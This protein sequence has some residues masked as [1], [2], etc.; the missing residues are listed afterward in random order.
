MQARNTVHRFSRE[1][2]ITLTLTSAESHNH[3][4]LQGKRSILESVWVVGE[5]PWASSWKS[6]KMSCVALKR[7]HDSGFN[8]YFCQSL[9]LDKLHCPM[10]KFYLGVTSVVSKIVSSLCG[11]LYCRGFQTASLDF[12]W[13][14]RQLRD[15]KIQKKCQFPLYASK[16]TL[17]V[18]TLPKLN[19]QRWH[20]YF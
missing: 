7:V 9:D 19:T 20:T 16:F 6:N 17:W 5:Q 8:P 1:S 3:D 2:W 10:L 18:I 11:S 14:E 13:G 12:A 15:V 4:S